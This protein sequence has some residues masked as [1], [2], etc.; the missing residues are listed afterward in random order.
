VLAGEVPLEEALE[1]IARNTRAY[2]RRQVTWLRHQLP[3][4]AL[5]LDATAPVTVLAQKIEDDWRRA[6]PAGAEHPHDRRT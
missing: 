5:R 3:D 6:S 4:D 2:A 1:R